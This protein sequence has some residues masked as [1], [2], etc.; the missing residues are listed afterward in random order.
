[1]SGSRTRVTRT[2]IDLDSVLLQARTDS[3]GGTVVF[4]GTVRNRSERG[5]VRSLEYQAYKGMAEK[6]MKRIESEVLQKWPVKK[7]VMVHREGTLKTGDVSVVVVVSAEHRAEAFDACRYA[8]DRIK[9]TLPIWKRE[10]TGRKGHW[11]EGAP[12]GTQA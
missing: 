3:A 6:Q 5:R 7:V 4:I 8:I 9:S 2:P 10:R 11:V 1:M 12:L